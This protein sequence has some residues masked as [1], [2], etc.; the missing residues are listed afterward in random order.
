MTRRRYRPISR[1]NRLCGKWSAAFREP[2]AVLRIVKTCKFRL[3]VNPVNDWNEWNF[4]RLEP[5][6]AFNVLNGAQRLNNWNVWN[7]PQY[8]FERLERR[9]PVKRI[10]RFELPRRKRVCA[11]NLFHQLDDFRVA[12]NLFQRLLLH[13]SR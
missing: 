7:G 4:G 13:L 11:G 3:F 6:L 5:A 2:F 9:E 8:L 12:R 1:P 10:E